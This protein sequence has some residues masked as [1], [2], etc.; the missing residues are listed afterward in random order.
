MQ[1]E[2]VSK[3]IRPAIIVFVSQRCSAVITV[4]CTHV[5]HLTYSFQVYLGNQAFCYSFLE[6]IDV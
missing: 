1:H 4:W 3:A 5:Q 2:A 6:N